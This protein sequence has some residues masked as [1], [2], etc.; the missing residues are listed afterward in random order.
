MVLSTL[1]IV[2]TLP[3]I[4]IVKVLVYFVNQVMIGPIRILHFAKI[5][6][7]ELLEIQGISIVGTYLNESESNPPRF[8]IFMIYL[9]EESFESPR[10]HGELHLQYVERFQTTD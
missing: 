7:T 1:S 6:C 2:G 8:A 3:L 9:V 4:S 10:L 5:W